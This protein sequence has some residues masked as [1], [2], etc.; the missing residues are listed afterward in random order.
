M[1][2]YKQE[3]VTVKYIG[4]VTLTEF[5]DKVLFAQKCFMLLQQISISYKEQGV[6]AFI[7]DHWLGDYNK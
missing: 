5:V 7:L 1:H 6:K 3:L 4:F 2:S